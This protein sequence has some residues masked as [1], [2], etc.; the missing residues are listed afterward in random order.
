M[1]TKEKKKIIYKLGGKAFDYYQT[2]G[3]PPE[4]FLEELKRELPYLFIDEEN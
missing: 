4:M 1:T 2:Y 3:F